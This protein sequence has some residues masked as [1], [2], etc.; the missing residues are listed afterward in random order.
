MTDKSTVLVAI[1]GGVD[2]SVAAALLQQGGYDV[3]AVFMCL[4]Q[5]QD[6]DS[7]HK[8]CCSPEDARDAKEVA[9][10][11]GIGFHVLD[12]QKELQG[13]IDYFVDEYRH[14]RTPNPCIQC[15]SLLKF[16]K[17]MTYANK[18]GIDYVATGHYARVLSNDGSNHL[19]RGADFNKDQSYALFG[20]ERANLDKI[21]LPIG[22]Y[23][24]AQVRE[25]AKVMNLT[26]HDK[27]ESQEICF[28]P[29]DDYTHL[30]EARAPELARPG[31]VVDTQGKVLGGHKGIYRY[32]I[33]QRRGLGIALGEAAYVV[34]LDAEN[35]EVVLGSREE[36]MGRKLW[37]NGVN[38]LVDEIPKDTI[39]A[40]VQI[41]YNHRGAPAKVTPISGDNG[42]I[43]EVMV[44][45][46]EPISAITPGQAAVFY[47]DKQCVIGGGWIVR[48][49]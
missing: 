15:N 13:I 43:D 8:G 47:D 21:M 32:T 12:F 35:N 22:E 48:G 24:K 1:S 10:R 16:G 3:T 26:V 36:L 40:C 30:I 9:G 14:G 49:E 29:D 6:P 42:E 45:F 38:W 27:A 41:R 19:C 44:E 11:L 20:M 31:K 46:D 4:G 2:S 28:V 5:A 33:G 7:S 18:L 39:N 17:L 23:T 37:A 25:I 34:R